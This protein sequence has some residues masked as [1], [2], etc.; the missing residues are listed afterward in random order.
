M[1]GGQLCIMP[2]G[3]YMMRELDS[4]L[5]NEFQKKLLAA[6]LRNLNDVTNPLAFNNFS[7]TFRELVRHVLTELAPD[8][9][10]KACPWYVPEPTSKT[11]ITRSHAITYAVQGG[12]LDNYVIGTLSIDVSA[13]KKKLLAEINQ[14]NKYTHVNE[15]T[16]GLDHMSAI[17]KANLVVQAFSSILLLSLHCRKE[18]AM[19][20]EAQIH[21]EVVTHAISE[22]IGSI[23][24]LASHHYVD[25]IYLDEVRVTKICSRYIHLTA[26][27][28]VGAELQWGSNG[29][30]RRGDGV[31][32]SETFP[33]SCELQISVESPDEIEVCENGLVVDTSDWWEGYYDE[34]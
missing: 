32:L 30:V 29:D 34:A 4:L 22:T 19:A 10:I 5:H 9:E 11:G 23:D 15:S 17:E 21:D 26:S 6:S 28:S 31:L 16:F 20:L 33:F 12:L 14:L 25:E 2:L 7:A 24:E 8:E 18:L 13:K 27:G 1:P 3:V